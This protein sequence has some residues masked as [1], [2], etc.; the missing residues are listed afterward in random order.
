VGWPVSIEASATLAVIG[1][2]TMGRGLAQVALA[3]GMSVRLADNEPAQLAAARERVIARLARD[4]IDAGSR[5][6]TGSAAEMCAGADLVIEAVFE[7]VEVKSTVLATVEAVVAPDS[8]IATNT[9]GIPVNTLAAALNDPSRFVGMHFFNPV[10]RMALVEVI[11]AEATSDATMAAANALAE[12]MGKCPVVVADSPGF[13]ASRLNCV[14]GNEALRMLQDG[15]ADPEAIDTAAKLGLNHPMG[16]LELLDLVGL[17]VRLAALRTLEHA[18][19]ERFAPTQ[20]HQELVTKGRLG[21]KS[22][23]GVYDYDEDGRRVTP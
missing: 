16:P 11:P 22:R 6:R 4:G 15:I 5:L 17:D 3:A 21:V 2:G 14:L 7:D 23:A 9:S 10:H 19:G 12:A 1:A 8:V 20:L 13:V 18:Y